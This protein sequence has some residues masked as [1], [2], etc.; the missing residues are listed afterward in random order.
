MLRSPFRSSQ[1][2]TAAG[3]VCHGLEDRAGTPSHPTPSQPTPS[4]PTPSVQVKG[5]ECALLF[6]RILLVHVHS[7]FL[8]VHPR[9]VLEVSAGYGIYYFTAL[10]V[11]AGHNTDYA[12]STA[13]LAASV[14]D[15]SAAYTSER[16]TSFL[17]YQDYISMCHGAVRSIPVP[18]AWSTMTTTAR[19][20]A[21]SASLIETCLG[22]SPPSLS[23]A[24]QCTDTAAEAM[25]A[26]ADNMHLD[27]DADLKPDLI[28]FLQGLQMRVVAMRSGGGGGFACPSPSDFARGSSFV[29]RIV[30]HAN[31]ALTVVT[32]KEVADEVQDA[33]QALQAAYYA[34]L[35]GIEILRVMMMAESAPAVAAA[36]GGNIS[37]SAAATVGD[38][39]V[40]PLLVAASRLAD[41]SGDLQATHTFRTEPAQ[42]ALTALANTAINAAMMLLETDGNTTAM[43]DLVNM[44]STAWAAAMTDVAIGLADIANELI[45]EYIELAE[46]QWVGALASIATPVSTAFAPEA[47]RLLLIRSSSAKFAAL[48]SPASL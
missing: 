7:L 42:F 43:L 46:Q 1:T 19:A 16:M 35:A 14:N 32:T 5:L 15:W 11:V 24:R 27:D 3:Y 18:I 41:M 9:F 25:L 21:T 34:E 8:L 33:G 12:R 22:E 31:Q 39:A 47:V 36:S 29:A 26:A 10:I 17:L 38:A 13:Q 30:Q 2:V 44:T 45:E 37:V 20:T 28:A 48:T 4:Q 23:D 6:T 40:L